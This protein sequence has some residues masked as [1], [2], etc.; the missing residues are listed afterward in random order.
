ELCDASNTSALLT[1]DRIPVF[2]FVHKYIESGCIPGGT[3]RNWK[4]FGNRIGLKNEMDYNLIADP[5]TS[6]GLLIS[7]D[8]DKQ[9][10]FESFMERKKLKVK[11]IGALVEKNDSKTITIR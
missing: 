4:T 2:D 3:H 10:E 1:I 7:V 8:Q 11:P 5:Q 9:S 6:G